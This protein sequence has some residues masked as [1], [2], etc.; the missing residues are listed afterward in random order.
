MS[1]ETPPGGTF[2]EVL[3]AARHGKHLTQSQLS[4]TSGVPLHTIRGYEQGNRLPGAGQLQRILAALASP[5][6]EADRLR[7]A[8]GLGLTPDDFEAAMM[9]ARGSSDSTW[10]EVQQS[11][12]L[13][14]V[15]NERREIVAWNELANRASERDLGELSQFRRSL[16]RMAATPH[17]EEHLVNWDELIGRLISIFKVEGSDLSSGPAAQFLQAVLA[18]IAIEDGGFLPRIFDLFNTVPGWPDEDRNVHPIEWRLSSGHRLRF[19]GAFADWS[20]YD[21]MWAFDWHA[22]DAETAAWVDSPAGAASEEPEPP[23]AVPFAAALATARKDAR[24]SRPELA[25]LSRA[26]AS[27]IGAYENGTRAPSRTAILGLCRA[28]NIDGFSMNRF[29][30]EGGFEEEPS[31]WARWL[32]G[33]TPLSTYRGRTEL[34]RTPEAL[35]RRASDGLPWPSVLPDSGC[36]IVHANPEARR[37]VPWDEIPVLAGRPGPHLMQLMVSPMFLEAVHNWDE[38]ARV[39]LPG[40]LAPLVKDAERNSTRTS[41][42]ALGRQLLPAHRTGVE[43]L[44]D[45]WDNSPGISSLR[46]PGVRF[47]WTSSESSL[48]FNCI[49]SGV[50][51]ADPYKSLDLFPADPTTFNWLGHDIV[52]RS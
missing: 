20:Q 45:L 5:R 50:T 43:R 26:G 44:M 17:Y 7:T 19:A 28:L 51:A 24:L 22:A 37:L 2:G 27:S 32:M 13:T 49:I 30:R 48:A 1:E 36:H 41:L 35:L 42:V 33:G 3:A 23:S 16:L 4:E 15:M 8:A 39:I 31:D 25:A 9:R 10:S 29:L 38:V 40:R 52:V 34:R 11:P 18:D 14:L 46:R 6:E 21:G 47:E 12:W